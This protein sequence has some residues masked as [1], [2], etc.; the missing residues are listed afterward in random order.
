MECNI[1][2]LRTEKQEISCVCALAV[3]FS[4][5]ETTDDH[6]SVLELKRDR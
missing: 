5:R 4:A 2:R 3:V 6:R 1:V